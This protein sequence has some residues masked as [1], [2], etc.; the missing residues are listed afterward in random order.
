MGWRRGRSWEGGSRG[1]PGTLVSGTEVSLGSDQA[2]REGGEL[3]T[4]DQGVAQTNQCDFKYLKLG[5]WRPTCKFMWNH[6]Q[7]STRA[8]WPGPSPFL[9]IAAPILLPSRLVLLWALGLMGC[10]VGKTRPGRA[11]GGRAAPVPTATATEI[12]P[13]SWQAVCNRPA[14]HTRLSRPHKLSPWK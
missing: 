12:L 7:I 14:L 10:C 5:L 6:M 3:D 9:R 4:D 13:A 2:G 8:K 11:R 1:Q